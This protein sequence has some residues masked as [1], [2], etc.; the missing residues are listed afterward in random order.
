MQ[1]VG[2]ATICA[3]ITYNWKLPYL[4]QSSSHPIWWGLWGSGIPKNEVQEVFDTWAGTGGSFQNISGTFWDKGNHPRNWT[5]FRNPA[6]GIE[7]IYNGIGV[8]FWQRRFC[9]R[10]LELRIKNFKSPSVTA[11]NKPQLGDMNGQ[12]KSASW[13]QADGCSYWSVHGSWTGLTLTIHWS[14]AHIQSWFARAMSTCYVHIRSPDSQFWALHTKQPAGHSDT[15][16]FS[17]NGMNIDRKTLHFS[18]KPSPNEVLSTKVLRCDP[19][20]CVKTKSE[21]HGTETPSWVLCKG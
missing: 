5:C 20:S 10:I 3:P 9:S 8:S 18:L 6:A 1:D 13:E 17:R 19:W 15:L 16:D 11:N 21:F 12:H 4:V 2:Y 7:D 14:I